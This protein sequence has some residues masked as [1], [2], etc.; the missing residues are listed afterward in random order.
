MTSCAA[1]R[2]DRSATG[3]SMRRGSCPSLAAPM[4]TGDGLLVR[5]RPA[6]DG[7]TPAEMRAIAGAAARCGSGV[8]EVTARGNLQIRGLTPES[9]PA[10]AEA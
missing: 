9:V 3:T 7:L 1:P 10:L 2:A 6:G 5:L 4:Q 8:I